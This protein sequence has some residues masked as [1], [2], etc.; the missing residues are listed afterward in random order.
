MKKIVFVF[1]NLKIICIQILSNVID[2]KSV[3]H[4]YIIMYVCIILCLCVFVCVSLC[5]CVFVC[6]SLCVYVFVCLLVVLCKSH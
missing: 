4:T 6:V 2:P 1:C 5:L 3:I